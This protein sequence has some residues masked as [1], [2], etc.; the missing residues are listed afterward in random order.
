MNGNARLRLT[1]RYTPRRLYSE[2]S[3]GGAHWL[4]LYNVFTRPLS[5]GTITL[6]PPAFRFRLP[7]TAR[8]AS[9]ISSASSRRR[10]KR[11]KS[12]FSESFSSIAAFKA[13]SVTSAED[14]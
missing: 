13:G 6:G 7:D 12:L 2:V 3:F 14:C 9:R 4:G 10:L 11:H 8:V 5:I 1:L